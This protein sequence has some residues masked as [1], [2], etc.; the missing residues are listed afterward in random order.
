MWNA[1]DIATIQ[2]H[3]DEIKIKRWKLFVVKPHLITLISSMLPID[4]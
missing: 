1:F 3:V 4:W 2:A